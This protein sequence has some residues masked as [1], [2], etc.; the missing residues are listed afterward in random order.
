MLNRENAAG[1][2]A[3]MRLPV[4]NFNDGSNSVSSWD[5][6]GLPKPSGYTFQ[7]RFVGDYLLYGTGSGWSAPEKKT[8]ANLFAVRWADGDFSRLSVAHGVGPIDALG[9]DAV[10]VATDAKDLHFT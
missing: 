8:Q 5:Y 1:D 2:V 10:V 7:N 3:L 6:H 9:S 4:S